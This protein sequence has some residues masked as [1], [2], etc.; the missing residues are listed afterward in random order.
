MDGVESELEAIGKGEAP[1][2][3]LTATICGAYVESLVG[4]TCASE[5]F[6]GQDQTTTVI[7]GELV[8]IKT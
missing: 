3:V 1:P 7:F 6:A 8:M 2:R 5:A 4:K